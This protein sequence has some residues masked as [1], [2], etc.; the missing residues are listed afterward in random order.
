MVSL[1]RRTRADGNGVAEELGAGI[2]RRG[3]RL[4]GSHGGGRRRGP[5]GGGKGQRGRGGG[6]DCMGWRLFYSL[7]FQSGCLSCRLFYSFPLFYCFGF[8]V[9]LI[10]QK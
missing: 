1:P 8:F 6:G 5:R 7:N 4:A 3:R 2:K 10:F 9:P